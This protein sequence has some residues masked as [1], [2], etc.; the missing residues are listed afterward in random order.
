MGGDNSAFFESSKKQLEVR[1]LEQALGW[2]LWVGG[3][4]NND[5][6]LVLV[7][8]QKFESISDMCLYL[9]VLVADG[10]AWE[11]LLGKSDDSLYGSIYSS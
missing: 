4:G 1:L 10:H 3:I 8:I 6:E 7:V 9:W 11:V 2:A 5:I